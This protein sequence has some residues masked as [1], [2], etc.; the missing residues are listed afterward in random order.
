[1]EIDMDDL[2]PFRVPLD[3]HL[4]TKSRE[5]FAILVLKYCE[6]DK[7]ADLVL[8]DAPD[9]QMPDKSV[10]IEVTVAI[11]QQQ[12]RL[13]GEF[14][15][16]QFG[17]QGDSEKAKSKEKIELCGGK[18]NEYSLSYPVKTSEDELT[19]FQSAIRNKM[20]KLSFYRE[21]GYASMG[22]FLLYEE[23]PI[24]N[25]L[26][27]WFSCFDAGQEGYSDQY[28]FLFFCYD[29]AL[30]YYDFHSKKYIMFPIDRDVFYGL[31]KK[32]RIRT[33]LQENKD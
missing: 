13:E 1:M 2:M 20:R 5:Y 28:D 33:E 23:P 18:M 12:A 14:E 17:K 24:P 9:L 26:I 11:S 8:A 25:Q 32:A 15:K 27:K 31:K 10:G 30:L 16:Y 29:C 7:F 6:S 22:L 3:S 19:V 4:K 21:K